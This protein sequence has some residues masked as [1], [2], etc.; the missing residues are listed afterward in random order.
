MRL[1]VAPRERLVFGELFSCEVEL[2][3]ANHLRHGGH[4]DPLLWRQRDG[5]VVRAPYGVGGGASDPWRPVAH[6]AG[7][8]S[9]GV[10]GVGQYPAQGGHAPHL[11]ASG[12]KDAP[13]LQVPG[14]A[15]EARPLFEV[16]REDLRYHRGLRFV[17]P[18][19]R[20]VTRSVRVHLVAVGHVRP[21]MAGAP[22]PCTWPTSPC[23]SF[24]KAASSRTRL[25][26][27]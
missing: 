24:P 17:Q 5:R 11:P 14:D 6:T 27:P 15:K 3:L 25:Q 22:R 1:V 21:S 9:S 7:V 23:A 2:L 13:G 26:L 10:D 8:Y 18:H 20:G 16:D 19:P 12:C 4:R